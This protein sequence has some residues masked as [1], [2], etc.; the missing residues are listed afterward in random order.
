M[1]LNPCASSFAANRLQVQRG[2]IARLFA[3]AA[4]AALG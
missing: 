2:G 4:S 3:E 1:R